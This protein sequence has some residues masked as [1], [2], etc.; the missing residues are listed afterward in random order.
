MWRLDGFVSRS[1]ADA[2]QCEKRSQRRVPPQATQ[3][4][5]WPTITQRLSIAGAPYAFSTIAFRSRATLREFREGLR[6]RIRIRQDVEPVSYTHL[7][8]YKRQGPTGRTVRK[9]DVRWIPWR[10]PDSQGKQYPTCAE[11][12]PLTTACC[13]QALFLRP[14]DRAEFV[15]IQVTHVGQ[16]QLAQVV[17]AQAR[18]FFDGRATGRDC[19]V[20]ECVHLFG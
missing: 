17:A 11:V 16:V 19:G 4:G 5:P 6:Y 15:A 2:C 8:V 20:M 12:K 18:R 3:G 13:A 9:R 1:L 10:C 7:D 14:V